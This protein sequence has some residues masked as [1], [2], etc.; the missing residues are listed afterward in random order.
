MAGSNIGGALLTRGELRDELDWFRDEVLRHFATKADLANLK[1]WIVGVLLV[2][3]L[4]VVGTV[5]AIVAAVPTGWVAWLSWMRGE[6]G[7]LRFWS[8]SVERFVTRQRRRSR[9]P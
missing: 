5:R 8:G 3:V 2:G 7:T 6:S 4:N 9:K 1:I